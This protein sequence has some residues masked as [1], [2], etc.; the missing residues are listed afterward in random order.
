MNWRNIVT[1]YL[2]ELKDSLRDRRTLV[3]TIVIPTLVMPVIMLGA[4][5]VMSGVIKKAQ[6]EIPSVAVIGGTDS[7][8]VIDALKASPKVR[9]VPTPENWRTAIAEKKLRAAV[10]IPAG[11]EA[12]M[13]AGT[14]LT[15]RV[16][17]Y[18]GELKSEN[19]AR[20]VERF[21]AEW[22]DQAVAARLAELSLPKTFARPFEVKRENVAPP[23]KVGGN[24]FGGVVPYMIILLCFV[25]A[26]YPAMDLTAGEKERGTMEM[27]LCSPVARVDLVLGKFLMVLTGS[28]SAMGFMLLSMGTTAAVGGSLLFGGT[29]RGGSGATS[30]MS[31]LPLIDPLGLLGVLAMVLPVSVLFSAVIFTISL[32]AKSYKEAQSYVG[33]L[34]V[35]VILP[36]VMGMLPGVELNARLALVP[37]MNLSLVCKEMLSGVWHWP[38]IALIFGSSC[39]YAAGALFL[40][41]RMFNRED[42]IF[43]A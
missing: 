17:N 34:V 12:A 2:K 22:R 35:L 4:G 39:A 23:E 40:A 6:E 20:V 15:V 13:K 21:F 11:F 32:F 25:G 41:V 31:V 43:R 8:G 3:S 37:I 26:M 5:T 7:P 10:E 9:V 30:G 38:Y 36:A 29:A 28:L 16:F 18:S 24:L 14:P 42:V 19:G 33:P 1:V 27:L